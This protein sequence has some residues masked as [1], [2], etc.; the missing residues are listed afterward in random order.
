MEDFESGECGKPEERARIRRHR[1]LQRNLRKRRER[2][3]AAAAVT[4]VAV[5]LALFG[6]WG[7]LSGVFFSESKDEGS[8]AVDAVQ[9]SVPMS[10]APELTA[11][12]LRPGAARP[13]SWVNLRLPERE[14]KKSVTTAPTVAV[15]VDDVGN[16]SEPLAKWTAIDAPISFAVFP[17]PPLSRDLAWALH[18][19]GYAVMMH[20]PTQNAPP[21]SF[22]GKG[23]LEKGM[24]RAA[25]FSMLDRDVASVPYVAG[26][27]NHQGGLGC[28]DMGLMYSMC[29]WARLHNYYVVDSNSSNNSRVTEATLMLGNPKRRNQVFIDHQNDPE[30][31]RGAMRELAETARKNGTAIGICHWHRPNTATVVGEMVQQLQKEGI[32]FAFVKDITN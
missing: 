21:N 32:N 23:Q 6:P 28:D 17:Y 30:Y 9:E 11:L 4:L 18:Q 22:S 29:E 16:T 12:G 10:T 3:V 31:I 2:A 15:V 20:I 25:V 26:I 13:Y 7:P 24:D 27:N 8:A 5:A 14:E 1:E 19:S